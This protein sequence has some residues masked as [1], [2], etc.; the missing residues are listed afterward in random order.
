MLAAFVLF[1][2][3]HSIAAA[4]DGSTPSSVGVL[5]ADANERWVALCRD[6]GPAF[7]EGG[8]ERPVELFGGASASGRF[9]ALYDDS[10]LIVRDTERGTNVDFGPD[11]PMAVRLP[12]GNF[13]LLALD[14]VRD[15]DR[16]AYVTAH[17]QHFGLAVRDLV[18][19][20]KEQIELKARQI[21]RV[22]FSE[23]GAWV[24]VDAVTTTGAPRG[25]MFYELPSGSDG[26]DWHCDRSVSS[27]L[28]G[29]AWA[30]RDDV[31]VIAIATSHGHPLVFPKDARPLGEKMAVP[32]RHGGVDVCSRP[33]ACKQWIPPRCGADVLGTISDPLS[34]IVACK[35]EGTSRGL[36]VYVYRED[37]RHGTGVTVLPHE[38]GVLRGSLF[39]SGSS[40]DWDLAGRF[41]HEGGLVDLRTLRAFRGMSLIAA[42][43]DRALVQ[44]Q[45]ASAILDLRTGVLGAHF[46]TARVRAEGTTHVLLDDDLIDIA[47][48]EIVG[49]VTDPN[50]FAIDDARRRLLVSETS[51]G[52]E[53]L[54]WVLW[55]A[56][57]R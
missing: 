45:T 43:G 54:K 5:G 11:W 34:I 20:E 36:P 39:S 23:D 46:A 21:G 30:A 44:L 47:R 7:F 49:H 2:Q 26:Y 14:P 15:R 9:V 50:V 3:L 17:G 53:Q 6:G 22:R 29:H 8:V 40:T 51:S 57:T 25:F 37:G 4:L 12:R 52:V 32:D 35:A 33:R 28:A 41:E 27:D 38:R 13:P 19:G 31:S 42:A 1:L 16:V 18:T 56:S 55:P 48:G 10:G 24:L